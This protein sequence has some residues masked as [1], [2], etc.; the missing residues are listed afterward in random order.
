MTPDPE[1]EAL[2]C[3]ELDRE[4]ETV[5]WISVESELPDDAT[6]VLISSPADDPGIGWH[7]V[8]GWHHYLFGLMNGAVTHWAKKL[9]GPSRGK[10]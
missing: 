1:S 2:A 3:Y 9:N 6:D 8:D 7:D 4:T 5:T 10:S